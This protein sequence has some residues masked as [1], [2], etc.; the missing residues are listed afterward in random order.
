VIRLFYGAEIGNFEKY[1]RNTWKAL[2]C[3]AGEGW[4]KLVGLIV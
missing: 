1:N 2:K 3:G 4:R